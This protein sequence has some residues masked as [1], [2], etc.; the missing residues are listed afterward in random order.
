[1][2][3]HQRCSEEEVQGVDVNQ[4][5]YITDGYLLSKQRGWNK[6]VIPESV[7]NVRSIQVQAYNYSL[8]DSV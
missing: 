6:H 5:S 8:H 2:S 4:G 7:G 1:M 3:S